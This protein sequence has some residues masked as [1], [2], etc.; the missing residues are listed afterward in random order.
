MSLM[1]S[2]SQRALLRTHGLLVARALLGLLFLVSGFTK[3]TS[4]SGVSGF[5]EGLAGR[6]FP[7]P[8]VFAWVVVLLL[9]VGGAMLILGYRVGVA[10]AVLIGFLILTVL[11]VHN[12]LKDAGELTAAL[13]NLAVVGGLLYVLAYGPGE[14]WR[15]TKQ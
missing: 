11:V 6:G 7:L 10:A 2:S 15:A 8:I 9:V 3:L 12:P 1:L 5:A 14:G 13:Q 4:D